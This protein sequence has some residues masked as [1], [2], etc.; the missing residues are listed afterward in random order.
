M[1]KLLSNHTNA[2]CEQKGL[3]KRGS[4]KIAIPQ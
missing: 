3:E 4:P 2:G 1:N